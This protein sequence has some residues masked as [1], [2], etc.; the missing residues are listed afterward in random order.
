MMVLEQIETIVTDSIELDS[1]NTPFSVN[2]HYSIYQLNVEQSGI[3]TC[4]VQVFL[5]RPGVYLV[6]FR[7]G[8]VDIFQFKRF[9]EDVRDKLAECVAAH[10]SQA[11]NSTTSLIGSTNM[12]PPRLSYL[13]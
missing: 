4:A 3:I 11:K 6:E 10:E 13:R 7:R 5:L 9:Y 12:T 8:Q 2:V 1:S